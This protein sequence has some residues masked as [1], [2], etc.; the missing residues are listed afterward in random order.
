[1]KYIKIWLF[2]AIVVIA[3][4]IGFAMGRNYEDAN[5]LENQDYQAACVLGDICRFASDNIEGFDELY[6]DYVSNLDTDPKLTI[7]R[8]DLEDYYWCY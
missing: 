2:A 5:R 8:K 6:Y 7:T 1:M 3:A 4:S